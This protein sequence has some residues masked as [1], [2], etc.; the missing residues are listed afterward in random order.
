MTSERAHAVVVSAERAH[1]NY[2]AIWMWLVV[3]LVAGVLASYL[4]LGKSAVIFLIFL[5]ATIKALLVALY[6]MHLRFER[7]MIYAM[8]IVPVVLVVVLT[9]LLFPDFVLHHR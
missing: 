7:G 3:L 6:Y 4:P 8:A 2:V 1:P 9:F 5:V